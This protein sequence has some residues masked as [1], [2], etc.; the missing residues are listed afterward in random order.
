[1]KAQC[2]ECGE[3]LSN[4]A[5]KPLKLQ[6]HKAPGMCWEAK[7]IFLKKKGQAPSTTESHNNINNSVKS[8]FES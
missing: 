7:R 2:V 4:E 8:H 1:M 3:I 5:L 6:K